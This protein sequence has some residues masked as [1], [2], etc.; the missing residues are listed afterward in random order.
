MFSVAETP[1]VPR[2]RVS[3]R[4]LTWVVH[5]DRSIASNSDDWRNAKR[6]RGDEGSASESE[7]EAS[8]SGRRRNG[9]G[10]EVV[11]KDGERT[12]LTWRIDDA[13]SRTC[14]IE[15]SSGRAT[16]VMT[17]S[18]LAQ[19]CACGQTRDGAAFVVLAT[20]DGEHVMRVLLEDLD[21]FESAGTTVKATRG[22]ASATRVAALGAVGSDAF[23]VFDV[24]GSGVVYHAKTMQVICEIQ[25]SSTLSR[26]WNAVKGSSESAV[27]GAT[28]RSERV[29]GKDV[30]AS[31]SADGFVQVWDVTE[32]CRIAEQLTLGAIAKPPTQVK[33]PRVCASHLPPAPGSQDRAAGDRPA[34]AFAVS[35]SANGLSLNFVVSSRENPHD[36]GP[37]LALYTMKHGALVF[38]SSVEGSRGTALALALTGEFV[39]AALESSSGG[40]TSSCWPLDALHR[41]RDV[42]SGE[43]EASTL[44]E[45]G[46]SGGG[47][48]AASELMKRFGA[49]SGYTAE[50]VATALTRELT[51]CGLDSE[52]ALTEAR[53]AL[54]VE[55]ERAHTVRDL[56]IAAAGP[57]PTV[58]QVLET[59]C[60]IA[61]TYA[62]SWKRAHAPLSFI[63]ASTGPVLVR[64]GGL[65]GAIRVND[66]VEES[67]ARAQIMNEDA[68]TLKFHA[69]GRQTAS[70]LIALFARLNSVLGGAACVAMDLIASGLCVDTAHGA[71]FDNHDEQI[72]AASQNAKDWLESF[73]G[74]LIGDVFPPAPSDESDARARTRKASHRA[75]QRIIVRLLQDALSSIPDPERAL[76][77]RVDAWMRD[78]TDLGDVTDQASDREESQHGAL[79]LNAARQQARARLEAARGMV[80]L[81]GCVRLGPKIGFPAVA[82]ES[83]S[84]VLPRAMGAYRSAILSSWLLTERRSCSSVGKTD[85]PRLAVVLANL[86][87]DEVKDFSEGSGLRRAGSLVDASLAAGAATSSSQEQRVIEIGTALYA[88]GEIDALGTLLAFARQQVPGNES[89]YDASFDAPAPLF[90]QALWTCADL[91]GLNDAEDAS[92][93]VKSV[94]TAI[95]LF[96]RVAAFIPKAPSP[97]D[98]LLVQLLRVI[99]G[100]LMG[101][102][103][104]F[105][106]DAVSRLE[107]YEVVMLFFERLGCAA[108]AAAAAYAALHEVQ[109]DENQSAR[110]W[111]NVLQYAVDA[112]DWRAAY[113]AATSV[114]G[115]HRQAAAMRRLVA[116]VC[117]PGA[118]NGGAVLS[119]LC[120]DETDG[121]HYQTVVNA[122]EGRASTAQTDA[123]SEILYGFYLN[124]GDPEKAAVSMHAFANRLRETTMET[125]RKPGVSYEELVEALSRQSSALLASANALTVLSDPC[126]VSFDAT[127]EDAHMEG[128]D[129]FFAANVVS[130]G[131]DTKKS[132]LATVLSEYAL[133]AA[134]LELLHAGCDISA[135]RFEGN[136]RE[137]IPSLCRLLIEYGCFTAATTLC[138]A[139]LDG[140]KLTSALTLVAGTMAARASMIQIGD[141]S[142]MLAERDDAT[143]QENAE[144]SDYRALA[145][146]IG[147]DPVATSIDSYWSELRRFVERFDTSD[148]NFALSEAVARSI[149][150]IDPR[151][152]LPHWLV[153]RFINPESIFTS[154]GMARRGANPAA[155]LRV[156][157]EFNRVEEAAQLS[158]KELTS[159]SKRSA[160][161]RT[162][163]GACWF[164]MNLIL[165]ARDRCTQNGPLQQLR[166]ALAKAIK[167]HET[168]TKADSAMLAQVSA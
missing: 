96:S 102:D 21:D 37:Q 76:Q 41:A 114:A 157:L 78:P 6:I 71:A 2:S 161:D 29:S 22:P 31:I 89:I 67:N 65:L 45:W 7:T 113:C 156:Y 20:T 105:P 28:P 35:P 94:D 132:P 54:S 109:D 15:S 104:A 5:P 23:A 151:I 162:A 18:A 142:T 10:A 144:A 26:V 164:P 61:P 150:S 55:A 83:I 143:R 13:R 98:A 137:V 128:N 42:R 11:D 92:E 125:A 99:Q 70:A 147:V 148:R 58:A 139:W 135:L 39:V 3:T 91:A 133:S 36:K 44:E 123:P 72:E 34:Y 122:L 17:P 50:S 57:S 73:A 119:T 149:L 158:L 95:A 53:C 69:G 9:G 25:S 30:V 52:E 24:S 136:D 79:V 107:Y 46:H 14:V 38:T 159:W 4:P 167:S 12:V 49:L 166:E 121:P 47:N 51:S 126:S 86:N 112:R 59:W 163:H 138:T 108:G 80:L 118:K 16:R 120:L 74:A 101:T 165:E 134:R 146:L 127:T 154:R 68:P 1:V 84:T 124:R 40:C 66:E 97:V 88:A 8:T 64:A 153:K 155:L 160:I 93:R 117:E 48:D 32:A 140:E 75:R 63:R 103:D 19:T 106:D 82:A 100:T 168:R 85:A 87:H 130:S 43:S 116:S 129:D 141:E 27:I 131:Q 152:A 115:E 77:E 62:K 33:A 60:R 110:L 111:A 56:V 81:L 90:L 145:G